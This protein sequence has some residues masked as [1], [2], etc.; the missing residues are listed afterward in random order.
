[1]PLLEPTNNNVL[2]EVEKE[3]SDVSR[4]DENENLQTGK[5]VAISVSHYHLTASSFGQIESS[6]LVKVKDQFKPGT[7]VRWEQFAEG[8]QTFDEDGKVYAIVPWWRLIS[9]EETK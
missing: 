3:Y 9:R 4:P 6:H 7:T 1:M 5:V 8:G 2:I